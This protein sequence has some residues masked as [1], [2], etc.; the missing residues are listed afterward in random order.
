VKRA[1][2]LVAVLAAACATGGARKASA[3]KEGA[4][5]VDDALHGVKYTL[6]PSADGWQVAREGAAHVSASGVQ[7]Q[8]GSFPLTAAAQA[9][10]CREAARNR[11]AAIRQK[12][13]EREQKAIQNVPVQ[14]EPRDEETAE[15]PTATWAFTRGPAAAAVRSRWAFYARGSDCLM[16]EVSGPRGDAFGDRVFASAARTFRVLPLPPDRQRE[17]D[18]LAGMGFLERRDPAAALDRFETLSRREPDFAKAHFGA[19][20]AAFEMGAQAY[21]R[22][23]PHGKAALKADRDLTPEQRQLALRAVGVMQLAEN[24]VKDASE[25]LAELV[26]RAPDLAEG[27]Y[28]YAC[29]LARLGERKQALEHLRTAIQ[30]DGDLATH[31]LGDSDFESLRNSPEFESLTHPPQSAR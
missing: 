5:E 21:A 4:I 29:A 3:P 17:V 12:D 2:L 23:L 26:V 27:Q 25:T 24:E 15:S 19:L 11:L 18:L 22:G 30:L 31:A 9:G 16:L 20:M 14:A 1:P 10:S 7:V 8:V 13:E 6:P 28:N